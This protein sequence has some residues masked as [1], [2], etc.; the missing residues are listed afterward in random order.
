MSVSP[1]YRPDPVY[2]QIGDGF[3]DSVTAAEFPEHILRYRNTR[4]AK[5]VGLDGLTDAEWQEHFGAFKPL[6]HNLQPPLAMRYHGHQFRAYNPDIGDGRGFLFAQLRDTDDRLLDLGTKGSG[7]TP[8]SRDGDGRL[9]LKGGVRE[10]LVTALLEALGVNTSKSFSLIETGESLYRS[11]EPSPTRSSVLVRLSHSH[12]RFGTFQRHAYEGSP[13]RL[14]TLVDFC[15]RHYYPELKGLEGPARVGAFLQKVCEKTGEMVG[16]W[17]LAG[18]VHGVVNT[19][20]MNVTGESFDY[21]PYR[22]LP[23][24]DPN[25]VAAYFDQTGLYSFL[26]QIE[27]GLWNV[28]QLAA[29]LLPICDKETL[30]EALQYYSSSYLTAVGGAP[31]IGRLG[32]RSQGNHTDRQLSLGVLNFMRETDAPFEQFYFD[33]YGG[34]IREARA[35]KSSAASYYQAPNFQHVLSI[36]RTYEPADPDRLSHVYFQNDRPYT[37]LIDE[38]EALWD[39]IAKDDDWSAFEQKLADIEVM[40]DALQG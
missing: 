32:V 27:T 29:A 2:P 8:Y 20:N 16:S 21:G 34:G 14:N 7:K 1:S 24:Y 35:M 23:Y 33:W 40:R 9:T 38:I 5:R 15:I 19:D 10:V 39:R 4:W 22:M 17:M 3:Y 31:F 12:I 26:R 25:F 13:E 28:Q 30:I 18:F 6:P 37:L 36:L 11:D